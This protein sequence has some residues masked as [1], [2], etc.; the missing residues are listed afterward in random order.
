ML[1]LIWLWALV[2]CSVVAF[3]ALLISLMNGIEETQVM[4][5]RFQPS[6]REP[7]YGLS[8]LEIEWR[9][10]QMRRYQRKAARRW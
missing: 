3:I 5:R 2:I 7:D 6:S 9:L 1:V 8:K 10:F 4:C